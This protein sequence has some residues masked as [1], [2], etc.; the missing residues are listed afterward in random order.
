MCNLKHRCWCRWRNNTRIRNKEDEQKE[1][2]WKHVLG[3][4]KSRNERKSKINRRWQQR[5]ARIWTK[6][7]SK[8]AEGNNVDKMSHK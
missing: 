1:L 6:K 4:D 8:T 5:N 3:L 7:V 2:R